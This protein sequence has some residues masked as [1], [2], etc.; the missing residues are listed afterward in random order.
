MTT[1]FTA[2][3]GKQGLNPTSENPC[4][5]IDFARLVLHDGASHS[6]QTGGREVL[7]VLF[8][9]RCT[10][11]A[12]DLVDAGPLCRSDQRI[13]G[14]QP[15]QAGDVPSGADGEPAGPDDPGR[16]AERRHDPHRDAQ[17]AGHGHLPADRPARMPGQA[18]DD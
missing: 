12:H 10:V 4:R 1:Y 3:D 15:R 5:L 8:G 9:G 16:N 2:I 14:L 13:C 17:A 6:G 7:L 18:R 11:E